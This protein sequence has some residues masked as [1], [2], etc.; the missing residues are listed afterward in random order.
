[1]NHQP[2]R[3]ASLQIAAAI[4]VAVVL[5]LLPTLTHG[6]RARRL[7][8][9]PLELELAGPPVA[10]IPGD[11]DGD[12]RMDLFI[13]TAYTFWGET[14][15]HHTEMVDGRMWEMVSVIPT[16][17]DRREMQLY[18]AQAD[19]TYLPA[20]PAQALPF[21]ILAFD[22]GPSD[23][24]IVA[25]THDG[26]AEV[27]FDPQSPSEPLSFSP[28]IQKPPV[29]SGSKALLPGYR[30]TKD[31][32]GDGQVDILLP[33]SDGLS[34]YLSRGP[35]LVPAAPPLLLPGDRTG[36]DGIVWRSYPL[37]EVEDINGD[38]LPDL[39]IYHPGGRLRLAEFERRPELGAISVLH[40]L[41]DGKFGPARRVH[42]APASDLNDLGAREALDLLFLRQELPGTLAHFGDLDGDGH[43]E[44]AT[45]EEWEEPGEQGFRKEMKAAKRPQY[46]YRFYRVA[47]NLQIQREPYLTLSA[48]G[49]PFTFDW[50]GE[51]PGG[52]VDLDGDGK[53][54]L[55]TV[56]LDFSLWQIAKI[57]VAKSIGVGLDFHVWAQQQDGSFQEVTDSRLR[58]KI[59]I[60][61]RHM[62]LVEF[63]QF[64]G[65]FDGDGRTDFVHLGGGRKVNIHAGQNGSHYPAK[66]DLT[67]TLTRSPDDTGLIQAPDL[68]GDGRSDL[69]VVTLLNPDEEGETRPTRLE[70]Y[71]TANAP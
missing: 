69:M 26:L 12:G 39:V 13:V 25:L 71:L 2:S 4:M 40:G 51:S 30:F 67:I 31:V 47:D 65:D 46:T 16:L 53:K 45:Y 36:K 48:Q 14:G 64:A 66:P 5:A 54:D 8:L 23:H 10:V 49:Y 9:R 11:L 63:A 62:R 41:G 19:G 27:L 32:D 37:P 33:A 70:L 56:D 3:P 55:V 35:D 28:L 50:L 44:V 38:G 34:I 6:A 52:F 42:S 60:N 43:A 57:L 20:A 7:E 61:L 17:K 18:L 1:M 15:S 68:D 24:P 59:K 22:R 21:S 58:G 29:F